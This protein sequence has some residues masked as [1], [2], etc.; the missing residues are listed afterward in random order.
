MSLPILSVK[1]IS[2]EFSG[3]K[4]LRELEFELFEGDIHALVGENGAG[5]STLMKI[6]SGYY[7][8]GTYEGGFTLDAKPCNFQNIRESERAGIVIIHQELALVQHLSL[9]ENIFL[10][11]ERRNRWGVIDWEETWAIAGD[12]LERVGL[13]QDPQTLVKNCAIGEQQLVEIAKAL[14]RQARILI[15]DEPTAALT[16]KESLHL[17]EI[18]R[19]LKK[20]GVSCIYISHRLHEIMAIADRITILRDGQTVGTYP[21]QELEEKR[22][23]ELMVGR[24]LTDRYPRK[25]RVRGPK[26]L[27]VKHWTVESPSDKRI[28]CHK[29]EF[30]AYQGEIL[31]ISGL[32]GSGRSEFFMNLLGL[33]GKKIEGSLRLQGEILQIHSAKEATKQ[34]LAL[35]TEDRKRYGLVLGMDLKRNSSLASLNKLTKWMAID[36]DREEQSAKKCVEDLHIKAQSIEQKVGHL[37]GGNQQKVVLAKWLMTHPKV[38]ILDEPTRGIDVG[39]RYE[40]YKIMN[41]LV[42]QGVVVILISSDLA[43]IIGMSDRILVFHEGR[44]AGELSS[45]EASQQK[46]MSYATGGSR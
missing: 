28:V 43:E 4:A 2:K 18:L 45:A 13:Q 39:A 36:S 9:A 19:Q 20:E 33:W 46:I 44:V 16:E 6:L 40:I 38:L 1:K 42:D 26:F 34:G 8:E 35:L 22:M 7:P 14:A 12:L 24:E 17:L 15:L 31:G 10:G 21:R 11:H 3:V 37:S 25:V 23:L 5:K 41:D 27:E 32:M 30:D 29:I